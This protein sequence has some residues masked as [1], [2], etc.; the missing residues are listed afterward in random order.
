MDKPRIRSETS[1][2]GPGENRRNGFVMRRPCPV[3]STA[4]PVFHVDFSMLNKFQWSKGDFVAATATFFALER[5]YSLS[6]SYPVPTIVTL[7]SRNP[8]HD[9]DEKSPV[10]IAMPEGQAERVHF[11]YNLLHLTNKFFIYLHLANKF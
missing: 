9:W 5:F 7:I 2:G 10:K 3:T 11:F 4:P 8:L 6:L 1:P